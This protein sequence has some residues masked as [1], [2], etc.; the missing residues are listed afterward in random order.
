MIIGHQQQ[1][2]FLRKSFGAGKA[3]HAYIF[4]GPAKLGKKTLALSFLSEILGRTNH[5][6]F[7]LVNAE[8]G[9]IKISQIR[10]LVWKLSLKPYSF[11]FGGEA[12]KT[13][14]PSFKAALINDAHLMNTEAQNA[15][16]KTLEEPRGNAFIFLVTCQPDSLLGTIISRAQTIKFYP[17]GSSDIKAFLETKGISGKTAEDIS[18]ISSGRPGV[19]MDFVSDPAKFAS[20]QKAF[21]GIQKISKADLRIRFQYAKEMSEDT[22]RLLS[23]LDI[24]QSYFRSILL[25]EVENKEK[26]YS[27]PKLKSILENIQRTKQL[28]L[29]TNVNSKLALETLLMEI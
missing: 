2:D 1:L 29:S 22:E 19:A 6:D 3:S 25:S 8:E 9:E 26:K 4:A 14:L 7:I 24:W 15:L 27:F 20:F 11:D 28:I 12:D 23:D 18:R 17:V 21:D 10:D 13:S 5:P 16:L